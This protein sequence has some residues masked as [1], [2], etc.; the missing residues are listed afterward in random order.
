MFRAFVEKV[1]T[2]SFWSRFK[3]R[4]KGP[5]AYSVE[6]MERTLETVGVE[7]NTHASSV[8]LMSCVRAT[9]SLRL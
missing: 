8:Q 6:G 9:D 3:P 2:I 4:M 1:R 7:C 5:C